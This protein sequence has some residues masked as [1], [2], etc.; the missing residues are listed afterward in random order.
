MIYLWAVDLMFQCLF[1][2]S[3]HYKNKFFFFPK[4]GKWMKEWKKDTTY[5]AKNEFIFVNF[6]LN[7][8]LSDTEKSYKIWFLFFAST[9]S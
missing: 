2:S 8:N 6:L 1:I 7:C 9:F 4:I 5:A 3:K